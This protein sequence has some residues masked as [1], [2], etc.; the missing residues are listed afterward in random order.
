MFFDEDKLKEECGV[1]GVLL[2]N[3]KIKDN[4]D[5]IYNAL[6]SLQHRGED[7]SGIYCYKNQNTNL[8]KELG[9][10]L[11]NLTKNNLND[12]TC[13]MA[14]AHNRYST[15][16]IHQNFAL[17][18]FFKKFEDQD[19][20]IAIVHNGNLNL[21]KVF[22]DD[23]Y[24]KKYEKYS[25]SNIFFDIFLKKLKIALKKYHIKNIKSKKSFKYIQEVL[26]GALNYFN[27]SYSMIISIN[28][29]IIA[30]RDK[31]GI[32]PLFLAENEQG[33]YL[34]SE[35]CALEDIDYK[36]LIEI[37]NN[38]IV[39]ITD[40][41]Y[42]NNLYKEEFKERFCAFEYIYFQREDSMIDD[43][44]I[45]NYRYDLGLKMAKKLNTMDIDIVSGVPMSGIPS[46]LA[47]SNDLG[48]EYKDIFLKQRYKGRSFIKNSNEK[49]K[50]AINEKIKI[51]KDIV[52]NKNIL[53]VDDSLVRGSTMNY[54]VK[55]LK[56]YGAKKI[57]IAI[58]S[59]I[60]KNP[61]YL[62][63]NISTKKELIGAKLSKDE[64]KNYLDIDS[65]NYL[66]VN[67]LKNTLKENICIDCFCN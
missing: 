46:A 27:G 15:C 63:I 39:F 49:I 62:G 5:L 48:I 17:Q 14:L 8:Y 58:T 6:F 12:F 37:R 33:Y 66:E 44:S 26:V 2:K 36:Q 41:V 61:C 53:I 65:L 35:T 40:K 9:L 32:R 52:K 7:G 67:D 21:K 19:L 57:H 18:P 42:K 22:Y 29:M 24:E 45:Y 59:P 13:N 25:D 56:E 38:S 54:I 50:T 1:F 23:L 28:D 51:I 31:K 43:K 10:V 4:K 3:N 34:A 30:F 55:K 64:I 60:I 47:I 16:K 20:N 11:N